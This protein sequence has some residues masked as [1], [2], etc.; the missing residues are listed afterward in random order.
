M[1]ICLMLTLNYININTKEFQMSINY[2]LSVFLND[3]LC[4]SV[5]KKINSMFINKLVKK[6]EIILSFKS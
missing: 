4:T 5:G 3:N 2:I 1:V 6:K